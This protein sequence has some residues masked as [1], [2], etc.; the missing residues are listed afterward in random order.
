MIIVSGI[1]VLELIIY[2]W[3]SSSFNTEL[4]N[5]LQQIDSAASEVKQVS[6][7]PVSELRNKK[8]VSYYKKRK[9]TLL[10]EWKK[11]VDFYRE[12]DKPFEEYFPNLPTGFTMSNF[13]LRYGSKWNS[14]IQKLKDA[15]V[16]FEIP[17]D[18]DKFRGFARAKNQP[19][20]VKEQQEAQKGYWIH[21]AIVDAMIAAKARKFESSKIQFRT[22]SIPKK[23]SSTE[24][25]FVPPFHIIEVELLCSIPYHNLSKFLAKLL[26]HPYLNFVIRK[27]TI[28]KDK[29]EYVYKTITPSGTWRTIRSGELKYFDRAYFHV[30]LPEKEIQEKTEEKI[31]NTLFPP[32]P[33]KVH[34]KLHVLDF[35]EKL[36]V[37]PSQALQPQKRGRRGRRG[38]RR[39]GRR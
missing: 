23:Q 12:R 4:T 34:L 22:T 7:K 38:R 27:L 20:N 33:V 35:D 28:T 19:T 14:L 36:V 15:H 11:T 8:W 30:R 6:N 13:W 37:D 24:Y 2:F 21:E 3:L 29:F 32:P 1:I 26:N 25:R 31:K 9:K 5:A 10:A 18:T 39:R 16:K 17:E